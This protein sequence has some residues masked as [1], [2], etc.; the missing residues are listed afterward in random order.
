MEIRR[1]ICYSV[2]YVTP[3]DMMSLIQIVPRIQLQDTFVLIY[4]RNGCRTHLG[5]LL[6][7]SDAVVDIL[8]PPSKLSLFPLLTH[9]A[10]ICQWYLDQ[11]HIT[12][13]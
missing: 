7:G 4:M 11:R 3:T 6:G 13:R 5:L 9:A 2:V 8:S 1:P 10:V 12:I